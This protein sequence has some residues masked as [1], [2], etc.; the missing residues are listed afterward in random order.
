[1][2]SAP[3][4]GVLMRKLTVAP[5]LVPRSR[6]ASAAGT[7]L[8]LHSGSGVPIMAALMTGLM[9][10]PF[11]NL[12]MMPWGSQ[13]LI[14]P[15]TIK[16]SRSQRPLSRPTIK[17]CS[18]NFCKVSIAEIIPRIAVWGAF[19]FLFF[20][21]CWC[22]FS[23]FLIALFVEIMGYCGLGVYRTVENRCAGVVD[24]GLGC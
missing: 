7:T 5:L 15:E 19:V 14:M 2:L 20:W 4:S 8:Q 1:M 3:F 9:P 23:Y 16:P 10:W 12:S 21:G 24:L 18:E 11:R 17:S 22:V 13:T 6:M